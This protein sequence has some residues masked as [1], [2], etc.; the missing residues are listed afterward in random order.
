[1][2]R[3]A[4]Q[5]HLLT[6]DKLR[7]YVPP[8]VHLRTPADWMWLK[9]LHLCNDM[10]AA[11]TSHD[12]VTHVDMEFVRRKILMM[13]RGVVIDLWR[14]APAHMRLSEL[15]VRIE[16]SRHSG[17]NELVVQVSARGTC[18]RWS[19]RDVP[20]VLMNGQLA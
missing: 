7:P 15:P 11:Y 13:E 14:G 8:P 2:D 9:L 17:I 6:L 16:I 12:F 19:M 18:F 3:L 10:E 1:M 5:M 20:T 4:D